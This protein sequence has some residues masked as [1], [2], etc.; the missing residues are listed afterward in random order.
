VDHDGDAERVEQVGIGHLAPSVGKP[1]RHPP[2]IDRRGNQDLLPCQIEPEFLLHVFDDR[3]LYCALESRAIDDRRL[4]N[5]APEAP[6]VSEVV[7]TAGGV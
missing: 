1:H 3:T 7:V 5:R 4:R 6:R 2:A